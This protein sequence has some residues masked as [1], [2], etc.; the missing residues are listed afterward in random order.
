MYT[1]GEHFLQLGAGASRFVQGFHMKSDAARAVLGDTDRQG[2]QFL[3]FG[4]DGAFRHRGPRELRK[5]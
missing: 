2:H 4:A 3:V 5:T 1:H